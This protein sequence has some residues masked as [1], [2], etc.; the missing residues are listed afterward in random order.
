MPMH[1][2]QRRKKTDKQQK[3][4]QQGIKQQRHCTYKQQKS[5]KHI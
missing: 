2:Q 1:K 3:Q 4:H 5:K